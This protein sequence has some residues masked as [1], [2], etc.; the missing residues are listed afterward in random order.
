MKEIIKKFLKV[1]CFCIFLLVILSRF[2]YADPFEINLSNST[3]LAKDI[4]TGPIGWN[5]KGYNR[6]FIIT[7]FGVDKGAVGETDVTVNV[8]NCNSIEI[9]EL[10]ISYT[11]LKPVSNHVFTTIENLKGQ[12]PISIECEYIPPPIRPP[13]Q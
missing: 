1:S 7:F 6:S 10:E 2:M 12:N 9:K 5:C 3:C 11:N 4:T 13:I 8:V